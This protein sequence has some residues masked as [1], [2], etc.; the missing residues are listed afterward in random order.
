MKQ[1]A[2]WAGLAVVSVLVVSS[3]A[4]AQPTTETLG[5][6]RDNTLYEDPQGSLSSGAGE[7]LYVAH[8]RVGGERRAVLRFDLAGLPEG[9]TITA[10]TLTLTQSLS[11]N[12]PE[13][14]LPVRLHRLTA[15]WG[16]GASNAGEPGG[17]GTAAEPGD[18][19]WIH[20]FSG[21]STWTT[22]GGDFAPVASASTPVGF[23]VGDYT[24][25]SAALVADL[26]AWI[27]DP[28]SN[29]GWI[30]ITD[31]APIGQIGHRF[32][33]REA[34]DVASRPR[35]T[36]TYT[37]GGAGG[38]NLAD[39][40]EVGGTEEFPGSPDGQLTVDDLILF[41]NLFSAQT[42]CPGA[43]PCNL[44]DVTGIGGNGAPPDG[45]LTVD[46]LIEFV[47]AF[48]SGC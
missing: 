2:A 24:W 40:T 36:I 19:T 34:T 15:D 47:N 21:A 29:F 9:A 14:G 38:C 31:E 8:R 33:S 20:R 45:E 37:R 3:G 11:S 13:E 39:I 1:A 41:V 35:L 5:P 30:V 16:E 46:D 25:S 10:A 48:S 12:A 17:S 43:A 42:G 22:P 6:D 44:A 18:A 23:M 28:A 27:A 7:N 26:N 32:Y 4:L